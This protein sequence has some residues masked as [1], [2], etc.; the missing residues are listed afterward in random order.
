MKQDVVHLG[1]HSFPT[2]VAITADEH[3]QGLMYKKWPPPVMCF[4]YNCA[5]VRKFWMKN[6]ISPLDIVFCHDNKIIA[7][8]YGEPMTINQIGPDRP[9][10]LVVE[11]PAGTIKQCGIVVGDKVHLDYSKKTIA[12]DIRNVIELILK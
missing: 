2:L 10:D 12:K 11:L 6:T 5:G 8:C 3:A 1:S 7:V 9:S 4:P